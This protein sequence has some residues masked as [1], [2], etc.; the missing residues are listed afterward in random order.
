LGFAAT[1]RGYCYY[2]EGR[3]EITKGEFN[4]AAE[5]ISEWRKEG[6]L[7]CD[8][9]AA[10][11]T[12]QATGLEEIDENDVEDEAERAVRACRHWHLNYTPFSFWDEQNV[13]VEMAVE[14]ND[15]RNLFRPVCD[16][17]RIPI[18]NMK[19]WTD[20]NSRVDMLERF[21]ERHAEGKRCV[22][23]VC[24][25]HDPGGLHISDFVH[26]NLDDVAIPAGCGPDDIDLEIERFGLNKDQIDSLGLM[27]IDNLETSSG[28]DLANPRHPDH[29]KDYVQSYLREFGARKV[30]ANALM[31][32]PDAARE[33]CLDTIHQYIDDEAVEEYEASLEEVREELAGRIAE[34]I[35]G[36]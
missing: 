9:V 2:L 8:I 15:L 6:R 1:A 33:V 25:D 28:K 4:K 5:L 24:G 17:F 3:G 10:D 14:K 36:E 13:Y 26:S 31:A 29:N 20:I 19:G 12:R 16:R 32:Q 23:L 35:D 11:E 7:A 30:E 21:A 34:L 22:L 27:W 18:T